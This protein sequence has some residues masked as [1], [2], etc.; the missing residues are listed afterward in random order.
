MFIP[1]PPPKKEESNVC[2]INRNHIDLV[3]VLLTWRMLLS[4]Y[5]KLWRSNLSLCNLHVNL[6][7]SPMSHLNFIITYNLTPLT[8]TIMSFHCMSITWTLP[9]D[10]HDYFFRLY[11]LKSCLFCHYCTNNFQHIVYFQFFSP[12]S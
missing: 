5:W 9:V 12:I 7:S 2:L 10:S 3:S 6:F 8:H 4:F 11:H 1:L